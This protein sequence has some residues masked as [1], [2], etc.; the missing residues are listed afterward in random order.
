MSRSRGETSFTTRPPMR[1]LPEVGRSSPATQRSAVVLP[2]PEG[3]TRIMNSPSATSS[4]SSESAT[5]P[6]GKTLETAS[7][8]T[9]AIAQPFSPVVAMPRMKYRWAR[10]N[11]P[12]T[13]SMLI[14]LAAM[15][16]FV[17]V[18]CAPW[19][20]SRPSCRVMFRSE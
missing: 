12:S 6:P 7:K 9:S 18:L 10:K 13:G 19:N 20:V 5:V 14:T 17:L 3:P 11:S 4:E 16:R 15:S 1:I 2:Q 8:T